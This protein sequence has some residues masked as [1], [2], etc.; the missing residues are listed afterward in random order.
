MIIMGATKESI[1]A[2]V[3]SIS[4]ELKKIA[5]DIHDHPE[6][7]LTERFA[8]ATLTKFLKDKG[9]DVETGTA[10]FDTAFKAVYGSG[11]PGPVIA[12]IA[13]YD[14]LPGIGH[15]CGHNL[16]CTASLGAAV[17]SCALCDEFGGEVRVYGTPAE[18]NTGAKGNMVDKNVFDDCDVLLMS[19][20]GYINVDSANSIALITM[21]VEFFGKASHAASAPELGINALDAMISMFNMVNA[22]RQQTRPDARIH[23]IITDG[24]KAPNIIPDYTKAVFFIRANDRKYCH[25]LYDK[26]MKTVEAAATGT[27][28][29]FKITEY[30]HAIDDTRQNSVLSELATRNMESFGEKVR[31]TEGKRVPGSSDF[32]N[33]SQVRPSLQFIFNIGKPDSGDPREIHTVGF[34]RDTASEKA[35]DAMVRMAKVLAMTAYDLLSEPENLR[36]A[37]ED[38][39]LYNG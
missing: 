15:G 16:I 30:H 19:H 33:I 9:F 28:C 27:G 20:P 17:A 4:S 22:L 35:L 14:A 3:D 32:G 18:E 12:F 7:G 1:K 26:V 2:D 21:N 39:D 34:A 24:G 6:I 29:T 5:L 38:F 36:K 13:E 11:K 31:R 23:G 25:E 37:K 10:G 8:C